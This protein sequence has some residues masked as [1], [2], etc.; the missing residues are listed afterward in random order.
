MWQYTC[1]VTC[2]YNSWSQLI[3][4]NKDGYMCVKPID[5][6]AHDPTLVEAKLIL[7]T[8]FKVKINCSKK[9]NVYIYTV[10]K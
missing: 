1:M 8:Y 7:T 6:L 5:W 10:S 4:V 2:I 3:N 9:K